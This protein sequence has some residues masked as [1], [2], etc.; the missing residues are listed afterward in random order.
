MLKVL[1]KPHDIRE[2]LR[3]NLGQLSDSKPFPRF[4]HP[5]VLCMYMVEWKNLVEKKNLTAYFDIDILLY[6]VL[7]LSKK[8]QQQQQI[9]RNK[10]NIKKQKKREKVLL[11]KNITYPFHC[12]YNDE[13][14]M[15][16]DFSL[17]HISYR[18]QM[19]H[20]FVGHIDKEDS[21]ALR[22]QGLSHFVAQFFARR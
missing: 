18:Y 2:P 12:P 6:S 8:K 10:Q 14:F 20:L 17:S 21:L 9:N 15:I 13:R 1:L 4:L 19:F 22:Q 7:R 5:A 11:L 16:Q 3:Y